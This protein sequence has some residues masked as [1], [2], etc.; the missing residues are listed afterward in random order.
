[1]RLFSGADAP[2]NVRELKVKHGYVETYRHLNLI[3]RPIPA[4]AKKFVKLSSR[5]ISLYQ[6][7]WK[8]PETDEK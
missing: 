5:A 3:S 2:G 1:M 8:M 4:I 6:I 7:G